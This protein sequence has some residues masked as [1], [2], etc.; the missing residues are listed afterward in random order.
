MFA[1]CALAPA[2]QPLGMDLG[3]NDPPVLGNAEAGLKRSQ[4][5]N[6]QFPQVNGVNLH[7]GSI[8]TSPIFGYVRGQLEQTSITA[9]FSLVLHSLVPIQDVNLSQNCH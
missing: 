8:L 7:V 6:I 9:C 5:R 4:K 3:E 2:D 1:G